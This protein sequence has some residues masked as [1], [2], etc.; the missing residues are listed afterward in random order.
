LGEVD[1]KWEASG[2]YEVTIFDVVKAAGA[3]DSQGT[4]VPDD[5]WFPGADVAPPGGVIDIFD[6][7][8]IAGA[9]G[10]TFGAPPP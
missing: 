10:E 6:I 8:T 3:Y 5:N 1:F 2:Y 9:Y 7:V 4:G